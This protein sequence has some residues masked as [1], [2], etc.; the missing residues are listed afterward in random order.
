MSRWIEKHTPRLGGGKNHDS[1][2][3][4]KKF[5]MEGRIVIAL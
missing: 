2:E 5:S 4:L 3:E 1:L